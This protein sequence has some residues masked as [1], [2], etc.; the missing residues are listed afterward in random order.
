MAA[1]RYTSKFTD[2]QGDTFAVEIVDADYGGSSPFEFTL[3]AREGKPSQQFYY[4]LP[5]AWQLL[6]GLFCRATSILCVHSDSWLGQGCGDHEK[7]GEG[8]SRVCARVCVR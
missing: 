5:A 3:G 6:I 4:L 2:E 7:G 1:T 8:N